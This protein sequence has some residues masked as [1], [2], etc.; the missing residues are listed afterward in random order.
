[1][2]IPTSESSTSFFGLLRERMNIG[3]QVLQH[4]GLT[5]EHASAEIQ[6]RGGAGS[7]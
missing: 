6:Q 1:M 2:A 5:V 3:A 7:A 4:H